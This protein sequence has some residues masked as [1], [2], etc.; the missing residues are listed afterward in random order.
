LHWRYLPLTGATQSDGLSLWG[1]GLLAAALV[2]AAEIGRHGRPRGDPLDRLWI[3]FRN[4]YGVVWGLRVAER[5]NASAKMNG[6]DVSLGWHGFATNG[7]NSV[8]VIPTEVRAGIEAA[9]RTLLR[10]F[11]S[12][13]W[14][15]RRLAAPKPADS[16]LAGPTGVSRGA[17]R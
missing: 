3:D 11:V 10:R 5:V 4:Q 9:L 17:E 14:I 8:E 7:G 1:L 12:G 15:D 16:F 13:E 2:V 6:W